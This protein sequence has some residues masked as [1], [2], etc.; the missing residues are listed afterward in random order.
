MS[1]SKPTITLKPLVSSYVNQIADIH[2]RA[3]PGRPMTTL[4]EDVVARY[5]SWLLSS[6]HP[7]AYRIG[8]FNDNEMVGF[9]FA[10]R[11]NGATGGFLQ[12][13]R[14][15]LI[16]KVATRPWLVLTNELFRSRITMALKIL[17]PKRKTI[18]SEEAAQKRAAYLRGFGILAI[19]VD[20]A[21]QGLGIGGLLMEDAEREAMR[22][23]VDSMNLTVDTDNEQAVRFYERIGWT[24]LT[25]DE[26]KWSGAMVKSLNS[27]DPNALKD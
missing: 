27:T 5:Y 23:G 11:Y 2:M 13:N 16:R 6:A 15:F 3:F 18:L 8:A 1:N 24:K 9:N 20:P 26:N 12:H 7:N 14:N 17:R 21:R 10:G 19:A 22:R 4:G 25:V